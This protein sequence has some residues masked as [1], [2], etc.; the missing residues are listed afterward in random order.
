M[1]KKILMSIF[2]TSNSQR[3]FLCL[4]IY[5][6]VF[7]SGEESLDY[8]FATDIAGREKFRC[9]MSKR[10][11]RFEFLLI[12]LK[13]LDFVAPISVIFQNWNQMQVKGNG[14]L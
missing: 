11:R 2:V 6:C 13:F 7:K 10:R 8:F 14:H 4:F 3:A 9:T 1:R 5:T 12:S